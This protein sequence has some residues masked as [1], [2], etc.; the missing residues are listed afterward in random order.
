MIHNFSF[1]YIPLALNSNISD[2]ISVRYSTI[3]DAINLLQLCGKGAFMAKS[4][5]AYT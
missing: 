3:K 5:I 1:P 4:D 2:D